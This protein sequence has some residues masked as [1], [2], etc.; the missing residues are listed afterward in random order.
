MVATDGA[1]V[2]PVSLAHA[3][4]GRVG[5]EST[6]ATVVEVDPAVALIRTDTDLGSIVVRGTV[7]AF[8]ELRSR[9]PLL[10]CSSM[11]RFGEV[12]GPV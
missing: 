3:G 4:G 12:A 9:T 10:F 2:T 11:V 6:N 7:Y 1:M 8:G 5:A